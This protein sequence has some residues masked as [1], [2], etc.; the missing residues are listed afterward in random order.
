MK[1]SHLILSLFLYSGIYGQSVSGTVQENSERLALVNISLLKAK[2]SS[3]AKAAVTDSKGYFKIENLYPGSYILAASKIGYKTEFLSSITINDGKDHIEL[4]VLTL[5]SSAKQLNEVTITGKRPFIQQKIDRMVV[6]V[7]NSIIASGSTALEVLEKAPGITIDRQNDQIIFRGKEGVIVQ[8]DGKQTY[9][10][11]P[12]LVNM[13]RNMPS[14]NIDRIELITNPSAKYDAAGNSGIIDIRLKKNNN[15]RTN[16]YLSIGLGTG[17]YVRQ[18]GNV[19]IN[20][21]TKKL[22]LFGSYSANRDGNY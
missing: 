15:I 2:N 21:R 3:L 16:G 11:M 4:P 1:Y 13:L 22:N 19:Q 5:I 10:S 20:H 14:D 12:D 17:R 6:D 8:I 7:A 18:R 9:L